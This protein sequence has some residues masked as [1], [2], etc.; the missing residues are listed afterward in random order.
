MST[1]IE[2][3]KAPLKG[4][5]L[6][7]ASAGTGKTYTITSLYV[8]TL[9][10]KD[11]EP[12]EILVMTFTE[13]ATA[14]LKLRL[15][16]RLKDAL[17]AVTENDSAEDEF[18]IKLLNQKYPNAEEKL[19][20]A[21]DSFDEASVFTIHG[22]CTRLLTEYSLQFGVSAKFNL[23]TDE[24][25]LLQDVVDDY[26]RSFI[27]NA[28]EDEYRY[29]LLDFLTDEGFGPNELK[30]ALLKVLNHP[31]S[32]VVPEN[33]NKGML[34]DL[35]KNWKAKFEEAKSVWNKEKEEFEEV[36]FHGDLNGVSFKAD[37]RQPDWEI[38]QE[39]LNQS[40]PSLAISERLSRFGSYM[41]VSGSKKSYQVPHL[42]LIHI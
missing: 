27:S 35:V 18:L 10:E 14:E 8:R 19:K 21:I 2:V 33:L 12:A 6:V 23:L 32:K 7:E 37:K 17:K 26:W 29:F 28:K 38:L 22:F 39:W 1:P 34:F 15:R 36:Y 3:F 11:L 42:S 4:I 16:N 31:H 13:A 30:S 9:L 40:N 20:S 5:S 24:S 41:E 25:E